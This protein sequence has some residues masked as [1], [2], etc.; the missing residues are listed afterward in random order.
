MK[1]LA[2]SQ[3]ISG[4]TFVIFFS[5]YYWNGPLLNSAQLQHL[6]DTSVKCKKKK[7]KKKASFEV[8]VWF[9]AW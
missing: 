9:L 5:L 3:N 1:Q 2:V 8:F 7:K 4:L 6:F